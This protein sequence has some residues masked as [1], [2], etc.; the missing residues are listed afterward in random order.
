MRV[1]DPK[2]VLGDNVIDTQVSYR[3]L[4]EDL[5]GVANCNTLKRAY[6]LEYNIP[7]LKP[8]SA[9]EHPLPG[10]IGTVPVLKG[11]PYFAPVLKY[12]ASE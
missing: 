7:D 8:R 5:E 3:T 4:Q 1:I 6:V 11:G 12:E 9:L 2:G 10:A